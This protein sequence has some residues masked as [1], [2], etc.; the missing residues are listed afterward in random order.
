MVSHAQQHIY[1]S[2][3]LKEHLIT[4]VAVRGSLHYM[5]TSTSLL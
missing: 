4:G 1:E 3:E 5:E 2:E